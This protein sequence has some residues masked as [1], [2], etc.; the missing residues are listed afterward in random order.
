MN[1]TAVASSP[2]VTRTTKNRQAFKPFF[3]TYVYV[4]ILKKQRWSSCTRVKAHTRCAARSFCQ[5]HQHTPVQFDNKRF[6]GQNTELLQVDIGSIV[7]TVLQTIKSDRALFPS[8][9]SST[10]GYCYYPRRCSHPLDPL[11]SG[12]GAPIPCAPPPPPSTAIAPCASQSLLR[13]N[14]S[15]L[16]THSHMRQV[17][18][19]ATSHRDDE[20]AFLQ[21]A[22]TSLAVETSAPTTEAVSGRSPC[23]Q[24][25]IHRETSRENKPTRHSWRQKS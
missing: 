16:A 24:G 6:I 8:A 10:G 22:A 1:R 4:Y 17:E 25:Y 14:S 13:Q 21:A 7:Y 5:Q 3:Y 9:Y 20:M 2:H 12:P 19:V 18:I 15:I 11:V 23:Q